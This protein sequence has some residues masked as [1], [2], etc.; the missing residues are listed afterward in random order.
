MENPYSVLIPHEGEIMSYP[1]LCKLIDEDAKRGKAR[2]LHIKKLQKYVDID[3]VTVPKKLIIREVYPSDSVKADKP[4]G[5]YYPYMKDIILRDMQKSRIQKVTSA[6]ILRKLN[7]VTEDYIKDAYTLETSASEFI[8]HTKEKFKDYIDARA[9]S[10]ESLLMFFRATRSV[11][12]EIIRS[13]LRQLNDKKLIEL[14]RS[15]C[16]LR[17]EKIM[18]EGHSKE[19]TKKHFLTENEQ[20]EY[21]QLLNDIEKRYGLTAK[22]LFF[23]RW[24]SPQLDEARE[25][26]ADA[27]KKLSP[28]NGEYERYTPSYIIRI[29][30]A[31]NA[32]KLNNIRESQEAL[33]NAIREY[34]LCDCYNELHNAIAEP[35]LDAFFSKYFNVHYSSIHK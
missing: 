11:L 28:S 20:N 13:T 6:D 3:C 30:Q 23:S 17:T 15:I 21:L 14:E 24:D 7:V 2:G 19:I 35:L 16:L 10:E 25:Y 1:A 8:W 31:G 9:I 26:L 34:A 27:A 22:R 29:T 12:N 18:I 4:R 5:K 33:M 32:E